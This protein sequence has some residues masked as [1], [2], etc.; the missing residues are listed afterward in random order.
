[1]SCCVL[2]FEYAYPIESNPVIM[3]LGY[4]DNWHNLKGEP[5]D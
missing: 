1:M 3:N 5:H 2:F 4:F